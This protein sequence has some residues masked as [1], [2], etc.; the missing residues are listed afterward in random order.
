MC[1]ALGL[2]GILCAS[3]TCISISFIKLGKSSFVIFSNKF[4]IFCFLFSYW[5]PYDVNIGPLEIVTEVAI[6]SQKLSS[7]FGFFFSSCSDYLFLLPYVPN[8]PL[9]WFSASS[10]LLFTPYKLCISD[11]IFFYAVVILIKFLDHPYK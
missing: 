5:Y 3:W 9:I 6:K 10:I 4:P 2:F 7:F 11:W 8:Q 1:L